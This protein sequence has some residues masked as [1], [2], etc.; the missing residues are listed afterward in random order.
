MDALREELHGAARLQVALAKMDGH[1]I[2]KDLMR[3]NDLV[4]GAMIYALAGV[5]FRAESAR[6]ALRQEVIGSCVV[7]DRDYTGTAWPVQS[8]W[9]VPK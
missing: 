5:E 1:K 2:D 8:A 7:D 4:E 6:S 9:M 3:F